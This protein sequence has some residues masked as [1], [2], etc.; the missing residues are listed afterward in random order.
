MKKHYFIRHAHRPLDDWSRGVSITDEGKI[1]ARAFGQV[2]K[3]EGIEGIW[4]SPVRRCKQTADGLIVGMEKVLPVVECDLLGGLAMIK[5]YG[6]VQEVFQQFSCE[7]IVDQLLEGKELEGF[8]SAEVGCKKMLECLLEKNCSSVSV[9]HDLF[10][11]LLAC[12][13]FKKSCAPNMLP[14]FLEPLIL[15]VN[16]N[17]V[18]A[19]YREFYSKVD[20]LN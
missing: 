4:S 13:I 14:N 11:G 3:S 15:I 20:L 10:I 18:F 1:A 8:Y 6:S 16:N 19:Q 5:N 2:L 17:E 7:E 12:Q 9:S